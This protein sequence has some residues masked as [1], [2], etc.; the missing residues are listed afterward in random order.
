MEQTLRNAKHLAMSLGKRI[1]EPVWVI[2]ILTLPSWWVN[3]A[4]KGDVVVLNSKQIGG[5][6][7]GRPSILSASSIGRISHQVE[8]KCLL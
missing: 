3:Q 5:F 4:G 2:P 6:V 1:G 7:S 8:Q